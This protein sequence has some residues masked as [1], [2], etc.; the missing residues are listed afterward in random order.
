[1]KAT[2]NRLDDS[3]DEIRLKAKKSTSKDKL[4]VNFLCIRA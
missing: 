4:I 1:M 2:Q 3:L